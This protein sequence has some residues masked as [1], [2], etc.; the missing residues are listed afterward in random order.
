VSGMRAEANLIQS[1][2][3]PALTDLHTI[4]FDFDGV[5]TDN[6][7][8]VFDDGRE[9][10]RCDRADGLGID[11]LRA[12]RARTGAQF[13]MLVLSRE[14]NLVV[15][16][17]AR[18]LGLTCI[19]GANDKL[20]TLTHYFRQQ[21]PTVSAPFAGLI[22]F[23]NDLND[24]AIMRRSGFS[25]APADAHP[26]I[27]AHASVVLPEHGGCGF[28]R[29]GIEQLVRVNGLSVAEIEALVAGTP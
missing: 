21:H 22:Y 1:P 16:A 7:V 28:V 23:G 2:S 8:Y 14:Q 13:D 20:D 5:F 10:V 26:H 27:R 9:A 3:W 11:L 29:A 24:L 18:K 19:Q 25:V 17:R 6:K 12:V 4:V 15:G